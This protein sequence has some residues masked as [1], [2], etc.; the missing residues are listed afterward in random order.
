MPLRRTALS[1]PSRVQVVPEHNRLSLRLV[2]LLDDAEA[3][4]V[5]HDVERAFARLQPGFSA[6]VDLSELGTVRPEATEALRSL[7]AVL[8]AAGLRQLVRVGGSATAEVLVARALEGPYAS[9]VAHSVEEAELALTT[10]PPRARS[11]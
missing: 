5:A 11:G 4:A 6:I 8:A 7:A 3:R 9:R 10:V 2:G 1:G